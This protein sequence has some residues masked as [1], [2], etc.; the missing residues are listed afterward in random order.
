M[1]FQRRFAR[2]N[3]SVLNH[4]ELEDDDDD[5]GLNTNTQTGASKHQRNGNA[6][7]ITKRGHGGRVAKGQDWWSLVHSWFLSKKA[8]WGENMSSPLWKR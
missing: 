8:E 4:E 7:K 1:T 6:A 2:E 5:D 3:Q